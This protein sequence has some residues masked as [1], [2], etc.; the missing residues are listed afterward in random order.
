VAIRNLAHLE[1]LEI[2]RKCRLRDAIARLLEKLEESFLGI[3]PMSL[4][5]AADDLLSF[6]AFLHVCSK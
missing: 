5:E 2:P 6:E 4:D 1:V 3:D